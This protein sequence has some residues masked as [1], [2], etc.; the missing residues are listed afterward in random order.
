MGLVERAATHAGGIRKRA[1]PILDLLKSLQQERGV[2]LV[3]VTHSP[4]V[5]RVADRVA[6]MVDGRIQREAPPL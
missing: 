5:A 3:L 6:Y 1:S 4:R 2:T